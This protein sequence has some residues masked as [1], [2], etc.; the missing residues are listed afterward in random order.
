MKPGTGARVY[1]SALTVRKIEALCARSCREFASRRPLG[2]TARVRRLLLSTLA[3]WTSAALALGCSPSPAQQTTAECSGEVIADVCIEAPGNSVIGQPCSNHVDCKNKAACIQGVCERECTQDWQ[4]QAPLTCDHWRC[5]DLS[6]V[7]PD[8]PPPDDLPSDVADPP[9]VSEAPDADVPESPADTVLGKDCTFHSECEGVAA[10]LDGKCAVQCQEDSD[11]G[12][13]E[14]WDC[15]LFECFAIDAPD[16]GPTDAGPTDPGPPPDPGPTDTGPDNELPPNC[17]EKAA[18]YGTNCFCKQDCI[19]SLCLGD[20]AAGKGFCTEECFTSSNCPGTDWCTDVGG[21][22]K[23][24]VK[25]DAGAPCAQ[26]CLSGLTLT[27]PQ[28][29]CVCSVPCESSEQ[30]PSAMACSVVPGVAGKLCV[31]IGTV[32]DP[33]APKSPCFGVCWPNLS[34]TWFCTAECEALTDCPSGF[35]CHT[36]DLGGGNTFSS[37]L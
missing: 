12:A 4:C 19:S 30:C 9:D 10:C 1:P 27:N 28:G 3:L 7:T 26:G 17:T 20:I 8:V 15:K 37:C 34:G 13:P 31:P 5:L 29:K 33:N 18:P 11:C 32:C 16:A 24:C 35:T 23:V 6:R 22:T 36:D 25:N 21:G 14:A 2:Y